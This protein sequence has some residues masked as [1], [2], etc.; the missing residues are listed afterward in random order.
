M[1][2]LHNLKKLQCWIWKVEDVC[3]WRSKSSKPHSSPWEETNQVAKAETTS[4]KV[5][6][7]K[8]FGCVPW[9]T[10]QL[11][12]SKDAN[13]NCYEDTY[14]TTSKGIK[15]GMTW[16]LKLSSKR[17]V[18]FSTMSPIFRVCDVSNNPTISR[19]YSSHSTKIGRE[20]STC[21]NELIYEEAGGGGGSKQ[22]SSYLWYTLDAWEIGPNVCSMGAKWENSYNHAA[23]STLPIATR[24]LLCKSLM[25]TNS[26]VK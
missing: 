15:D 4:W 3:W 14:W 12:E 10:A 22:V 11:S 9:K 8:V 25:S 5:M 13:P 23:W 21:W 16:M 17:N 2:P 18:I 7:R 26:G 6:K 24:S 19:K 20:Q 1:Y